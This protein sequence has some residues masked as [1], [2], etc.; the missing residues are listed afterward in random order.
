MVKDHSQ[1]FLKSGGVWEAEGHLVCICHAQV[2][3]YLDLCSWDPDLGGEFSKHAGELS[4]HGVWCVLGKS[5]KQQELENKQ[6]QQRHR[7][8]DAKA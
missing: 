3:K 5:K 6:L 7:K 1:E 8:Q 2:V 4:G